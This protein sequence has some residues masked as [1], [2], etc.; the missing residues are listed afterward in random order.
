EAAIST[1]LEAIDV[2][3]EGHSLQPICLN[4]LGAALAVRFHRLGQL[5]DLE[6]AVLLGQRAVDLT[7]DSHPN[8]PKCLTTL[9]AALQTHFQQ[10]GQLDDLEQAIAL[11]HHAVDL[12]PDGDPNKPFYLNNLG[13][14]LST[15]FRRS[16]QPDDLEH[17]ISL[18]HHA[19]DLTPD[20]HPNEAM[21]LNNLGNAL[22]MRFDR[23]GQLNDLEQAI[24][25]KQH[26]VDLTPDCHSFKPLYLMN[27]G[28]TLSTRFGH[29]GQ[30][31]DLDQ[32][33]SLKYLAI[34]FAPDS[35]PGKPGYLSNL[36]NAL[37]ARSH[38]L[39][40]LDDLEQAISMGHRAADLTPDSHLNKPVYLSNLGNALQARFY[41]LG[42]L[43]DLEQVISLQHQAVDL[44]PDGHPQ[45]PIYL[46][47]LGGTLQARFDHLGQLDDLEQAI[48]R[49][50]HAIDLTPDS[51]PKKPGY[52]IN[53]C[54]ALVARFDRLGQL[55]DLEQAISLG[56]HAVDITPDSHPSKPGYLMNL[57]AALAT[58]F[59]RLGHL[60]N[61][62]QAILLNHHAIDLTPDG[63]PDKPMC[64]RNLGSS[65]QTRFSRFGQ[66]NDLEQAIS[67]KHYAVDLIP[68]SHISKASYLI[69]LG[70][71]IQ[72]RFN[73]FSQFDD[74]ER[75]ISLPVENHAVPGC[76]RSEPGCLN[77]L[78]CAF[79]LFVL[80]ADQESGP[81]SL[82]LDATVRCAN[83]C[84]LLISRGCKTHQD[85][86]DV[87]SRAFILIPKV[88]W[89]GTSVTQRYT[90]TRR[91]SIGH[92]V[93]DAAATA[94]QIGD[95][96]RA[97]E[98]LEEGRGVVWSQLLRLRS[99]VDEL[100]HHH[101]GLADRLQ[102][103][104]RGLESL[105]N[106]T[107]L[108]STLDTVSISGQAD[109]YLSVAF[110][111]TSHD[112]TGTSARIRLAQDYHDLLAHIRQLDGF[113]SF[114]LPKPYAKLVPPKCTHGP[115]IIVNVHPS[116]C[117]ALIIFGSA[118][119]IIHVPLPKLSYPLAEQMRSLCDEIPPILACEHEFP[120]SARAIKPAR[121]NVVSP[122]AKVLEM[123]WSLVVDPILEKIWEKLD[124]SV[125]GSLPHVTWCPTGPLAFLPIHAAGIYTSQGA[126]GH[127]AKLS[128]FV[129]SSYTSNLSTLLQPTTTS[130]GDW[131]AMNTLIVSQPKTPGQV[132]LPGVRAEVGNIKNHLEGEIT[133]LDGEHATVDAVLRAIREDR[134]Q[135]IHMSCHGLQN[136]EEPTESAFALHDGQ[137]TLSRL[138][139]CSASKA[140]LAF[141][142][143]CQT[144][145]GDASLPE[146]AVHLAA[147]MLAVGYKAVIG[148]MWSIGDQ[149]APLVTNEFYRRL[150]EG[151]SREDGRRSAAY[152]LHEAV[153]ALKDKVGESN[154][155]R[156]VPY[157]HFGV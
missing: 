37:Q 4:N 39:G 11:K 122:I 149:D 98:W 136:S 23:L 99:P 49:R 142:S 56:H 34:D 6:Q 87:Y 110:D 66:L 61:L 124:N 113:E 48:S 9:G 43:D 21:Y 91:Y 72:T 103:V 90:S 89:L 112:H 60:D 131:R 96:S 75:A 102:S 148:T 125:D 117:D 59:D 93:S 107:R 138:M 108:G 104:S 50:Y 140:E 105:G 151:Y 57:G 133:H 42:Q 126:G 44:A 70:T 100:H 62:E 10:L 143:A 86:L 28:A 7:H 17:A 13:N 115:A 14:A 85:L 20:G 132:E 47:N 134:H 88:V 128:D 150:K 35:H 53:L 79:D 67:L 153:K 157:V 135:L 145:T 25:L 94:I 52:L 33:I 2:M 146:E 24:S 152:A 64:L 155:I 45:K 77:D 68:D 3:P 18:M 71:A 156:W 80:A 5:N 73:H 19:V 118:Q 127:G 36:G 74:L 130:A 69:N 55:N 65:L 16:G 120:A 26:A 63:H 95:L 54:G 139:T 106:D 137:L 8:K 97:V 154:F 116:R 111:T 78:E 123:L 83:V 101:P 144:S 109:S 27:L 147:G 82:R 1:I 92:V 12:T 81:P 141:L 29:L 114:L 30:L 41:R 31:N 15:R 119:P 84:R 22:E 46:N 58:R 32:A 76:H 38:H 40:K 129:V 51:H 121:A